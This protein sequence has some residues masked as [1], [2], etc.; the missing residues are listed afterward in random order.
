MESAR[1]MAHWARLALQS[2]LAARQPKKAQPRT[3]KQP[4]EGG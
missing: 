3:K 1:E 4:G 2:A